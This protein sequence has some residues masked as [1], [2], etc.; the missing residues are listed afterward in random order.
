M[1]EC[2]ICLADDQGDE[3]FGCL[4]I[5]KHKFHLNCI[6]EWHK[7][8]IDLKCPICRIESSH[9]LVGEGQH[10]VSINLKMGFMIKNTI[11]YAGVEAID[12]GNEEAE[13]EEEQEVD[14]LS[15]RFQDRLAI[16]TIKVIQCGVCGD[17]DASR[18]NLYCQYCELTYH[19]TCLRGLA[20]EVGER[21]TWHECADCRSRELLELHL[22]SNEGQIAR[23]DSRSCIILGGKVRS[24]HSVRTQQMYER[25]RNAK[26]SIQA[27]VRRALDQYPLPL[28]LFRKTYKH[29]NKQVSRKLY[30]LSDNTYM[31]DQYD[32]D[33]LA[34]SGVHTEL[35][36]CYHIE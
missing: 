30:R 27:H 36:L 18:L 23:Y 14:V 34:R 15:E 8:S 10:A 33:S 26:R 11:D 21:T 31:P 17:T 28:L 6:R 1:E 32:Y 13:E 16:D 35:S 3:R 19:E 2:P 20:C 7:Y 24:K 4:D 29:V 22:G 9:L 12:T 25:I 5:C